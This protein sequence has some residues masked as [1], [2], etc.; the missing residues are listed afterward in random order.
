MQQAAREDSLSHQMWPSLQAGIAE[1]GEWELV[2][3]TSP[4]VVTFDVTTVADTSSKKSNGL[5]HSRSTPDLRVDNF[6]ETDDESSV[7]FVEDEVASVTSSSVVMVLGPTSTRSTRTSKLSFRD[8]ILLNNPPNEDEDSNKAEASPD[9]SKKPTS[10]PKIVVVTPPRTHRQSVGMRRNSKSMGNLRALDHM[11]EPHDDI[12]SAVLGETDAS[13]YY[14]RKAR[15]A[16]GRKNGQK[17][18]PDEA[19]RLDI[20]MAKKSLQREHKSRR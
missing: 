8:A 18:R 2:A 3:P 12:D 7:V 15:G 9:L 14:S 10:K 13:E 11:Q 1:E 19:K 16:L 17:M 20:I 6:P 4:P 5:K